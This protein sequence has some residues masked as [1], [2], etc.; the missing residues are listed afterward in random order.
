MNQE[1]ENLINITLEKGSVT[2]KE[3]EII[4]KK[5]QKLGE[6]PDEID[7]IIDNKLNNKK[8]A[9]TSVFSSIADNLSSNQ[10]NVGGTFPVPLW[11]G[12]VLN[13]LAWALFLLTFNHTIEII[14]GLAC[15]FSAFIGYKHKQIG[16]SPF[17]NV[18]RL[19]SLN[20][21]YTSAFNA[22]WMFAWGLGFFGSYSFF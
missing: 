14:M 2:E 4:L 20:L 22:V 15:C 8:K 13:G 7:M 6:D 12:W 9:N 18:E 5:A 19:T 21:I 16:T 3:K 10:E 1:L 17:L 11:V